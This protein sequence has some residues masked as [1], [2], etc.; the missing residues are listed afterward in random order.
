VFR[1]LR[2]LEGRYAECRARAVNSRT[3]AGVTFLGLADEDML[4]CQLAL[5]PG[6]RKEKRIQILQEVL[7][8]NKT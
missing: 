4:T 8:Q 2:G 5:P 1:D 7:T 3:A 6:E